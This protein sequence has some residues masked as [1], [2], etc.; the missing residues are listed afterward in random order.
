[1]TG[2]LDNKIA[3]ITGGC[4]GM[5]LG[6][7]E[8][9]A[10]EGA[11]VVVADVQPGK[12]A[13]LEKR[14]PGRVRYAQCDVTREEDIAAAVAL[15][16][17]AFGGLDI[18]FNNA[19]TPGH[20][21]PIAEI[22]V[23]GW[24]HTMALMLRGPALGIKHAIPAMRARGGGSIVNTSSI[25]GLTAGFSGVTYSVAKAGVLHLTRTAAT[26]LAPL[27]IRVN[28]ICPGYFP[29]AI[30]GTGMGESR[31]V[32]DRMATELEKIF[33][34][35]QPLQRAGAPRDIAE[36]CLFL[37]SDAAAFI[38]GTDIS[39]DGGLMVQDRHQ[40]NTVTGQMLGADIVRIRAEA[41]AAVA[42]VVD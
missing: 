42:G 10:A 5:G 13:D 4:S 2:R 3:I 38:T 22:T 17:D 19:G 30:M 31:E 18:L 12:G 25:G 9:F 11:S 41:V 32:A 29:T 16:V 33:A 35:L 23:E 21:A 39:V 1:V 20:L 7:V 14:F 24:D 8:L 36:A 15:A 27:N 40:P 34:G 6:T 26:E 28:T 37:A